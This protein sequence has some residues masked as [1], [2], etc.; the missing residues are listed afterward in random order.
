LW[1]VKAGGLVSV[2]QAT[3]NLVVTPNFNQA[4][5]FLTPNPCL[6]SS[7]T[8]SVNASNCISLSPYNTP[9]TYSRI[10][11]YSLVAQKQSG[12]L[13]P[14]RFAQDASFWT[15]QDLLNPGYVS[16]QPVVYPNNT[17]VY[18]VMNDGSIQP[19]ALAKALKMKDDGSFLLKDVPFPS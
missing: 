12:Q 16:L 10:E 6:G 2:D 8:A 9:G 11:W 5:C 4:A 13:F 18:V 1:Y 3:G 19:V 14:Q 17:Y 15:S 7:V